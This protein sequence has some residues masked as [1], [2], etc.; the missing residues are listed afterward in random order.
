MFMLFPGGA[1]S[2]YC[3]LIKASASVVF[4]S[5]IKTLAALCNIRKLEI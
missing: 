3:V 1:K 5:L 2:N 4:I